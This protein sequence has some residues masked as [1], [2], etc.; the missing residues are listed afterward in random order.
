MAVDHLNV[1][2]VEKPKHQFGTFYSNQGQPK[3]LIMFCIHM[4]VRHMTD[5]F[6]NIGC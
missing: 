2:Y 1:S 5:T 6:N 3:L 4:Q